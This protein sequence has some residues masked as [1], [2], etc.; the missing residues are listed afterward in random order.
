MKGESVPGGDRSR[1]GAVPGLDTELLRLRALVEAARLVHSSLDL[2]D[3]LDNILTASTST[4]GAARGT[5]YVCENATQELWSRV[6]AGSERVEIRLPYGRGLAGH[7]ARSGEALRVDDVRE[8]RTT[9]SSC[10]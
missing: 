1:A 5:V 6:T 4:V 7:T 2:D 9:W 3:L 10:S 8:A